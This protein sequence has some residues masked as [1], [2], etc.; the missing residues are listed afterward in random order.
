M[1]EGGWRGRH[2]GAA[3]PKVS[4]PPKRPSA[5]LDV[6]RHSQHNWLRVQVVSNV[7]AICVRD[8]LIG[9]AHEEEGNSRDDA[10]FSLQRP[11]YRQPKDK[12]KLRYAHS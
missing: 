11:C 3:A 12:A 2:V 6:D 10:T 1:C 5:G 4:A 9:R 8:C 7:V